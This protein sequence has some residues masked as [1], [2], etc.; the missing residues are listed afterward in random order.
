MNGRPYESWNLYQSISTNKATNNNNTDTSSFNLLYLIAHDS[1]K[2]GQFYYSAKAFD[3]LETIEP[4]TEYWNG[5]RGACCGVFQQ[6][7]AG[8]EMKEH[9]LDIMSLLTN[10]PNPQ[11]N[12]ILR[13][14]RQWCHENNVQ[15]Y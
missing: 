14:M 7:I 11:S 5:K 4:T 13:V 1:Y 15:E 12:F 6:V 3:V 8:K 10:D 2:V 9:L